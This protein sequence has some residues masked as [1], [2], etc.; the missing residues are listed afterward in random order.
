MEK[1]CGF[2]TGRIPQLE[3]ISNFLKK[4]TGFSLRPA[5]GLITPRDFLASLAFRVFQCTQYVRHPTSPHYSPE[6][7]AIHELI[8]HTPMFADPA[9]AQ[10]VQELGLASLGGTD[11]EI[12][13]LATLFWFTVEF[14]LCKEAGEMKA[15][16]AGIMSSFGELNHSMSKKPSI[17]YR[18]FD[19]VITAVQEYDDQDYQGVYFVSESFEDAKQKLREWVAKCLTR[20]FTVRYVPFTQ[21]IEVIDTLE[22]T[23][24]FM[25]EVKMQMNQLTG[26]IDYIGMIN[27]NKETHSRTEHTQIICS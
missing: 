15:Y 5:A 13:K 20:P 19:P 4:T 22:S 25:Q 9:F 6:P 2:G 26:A 24:N 27:N 11:E 1:E 21:S 18:P 16:G 17:E 8:G 3:D 14:G 10:F 23:Q 12:N 7:D